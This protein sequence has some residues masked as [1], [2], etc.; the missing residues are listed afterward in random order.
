M[1]CNFENSVKL[2]VNIR[3]HLIERSHLKVPPPEHCFL[4]QNKLLVSSR[5]KNLRNIEHGFVP[6]YVFVNILVFLLINMQRNL[7]NDTFFQI[8]TYQSRIYYLKIPF[9]KGSA[10]T[11]AILGITYLGYIFFF[12]FYES[13]I[14]SDGKKKN[15][16][17]RVKY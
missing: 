16:G 4:G 13:S 5:T 2:D 1:K 11:S 6:F 7:R 10:S 8:V 3:L 17:N 14:L 12:F 15:L 9:A